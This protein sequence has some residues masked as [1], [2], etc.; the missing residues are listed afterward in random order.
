MKKFVAL[1]LVLLIFFFSSIL[2]QERIEDIVKSAPSR[3]KYP[4]SSAVVIRAAQIFTLD[5][6]AKKTEE[7]FRALEVFTLTGREKFSDFRIPFDKNTEKVEI[8]LAKTFKPDSSS[9]D[10]EQKAINDVT[11]PALA[12][13]DMYANILHRVLSFPSVDPGSVL[14]IQYKKEKENAGNIDGVALFQFDEP[15]AKKELKVVIPQEKSL[16]YK[17]I[18]LKTGFVEETAGA[19]K[20]YSLVSADSPQIKPEEYM[21]PLGELASRVVFS[22]FKDWEE[23]SHDFSESFYKAANPTEE[24]KKTT[25]KI[26]RGA[27]SRDEKIKKIFFFVAREIRNIRFNFGEGGYDVQ[28]AETVLKNRYGDWKDK[29]ALL[30]SMLKSAGIS[31]YPVLVN[32]RSIS[33]EED[34]PTLEQFDAI[35]VCVAGG[36]KDNDLFLNPL[37]DD[38]VFGYFL[39]GKE[40]RGLLVKPQG[41]EFTPV[42]CLPEAESILKNEVS[43]EIDGEGGIRGKMSSELSGLFDKRARKQL[44][45]KTGK[46]LD[47]FYSES[48]NKICEDGKALKN[49][50]TD[51]KDLSQKI[52]IAQEFS[53]KNFGIFQGEIMLITVPQ[54]PYAFSDLP[55]TPSLA[56][57]QYPFR[58]AGESE[59]ISIVTL[60]IPAGFKPLYFPESY[61]FEKDYGDFSFSSAYYADQSVVAIKKT[62]LFKKRE[63]PFDQYEEF[64]KIMDSFGIPKNTLLLLEKK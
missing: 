15:M 3:G 13:A 9:V 53:G 4:D 51:P 46:E 38:S 8:L 50:L 14:V 22:T 58:M 28:A 37:A 36:R 29:S 25:E 10:V 59:V 52:K 62:F 40:S 57:R 6:S 30:V 26:V 39:E 60:K 27:L 18:G 63:V 64:K 12:D 35:L 23:A 45:D 31:S 49:H 43:G 5:K 44:K 34:I 20:I 19:E 32:S 16:K 33:P 56:K 61:S 42:R 48:I 54:V 17:I 21:P 11:P 41:I 24:V 47:V 7:Y 1:S 2:A 55:A